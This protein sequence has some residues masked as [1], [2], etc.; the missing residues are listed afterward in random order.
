[1]AAVW[2]RPDNVGPEFYDSDAYRDLYRLARERLVEIKIDR[3][4]ITRGWTYNANIYLVQPTGTFHADAPHIE[5]CRFVPHG[6][7]SGINP[8][9]AHI[10]AMR[11]RRLHHEPLVAVAI[12]QA[13]LWLLA[14]AYRLARE[15]EERSARIFGKLDAAMT[16]LTDLIRSYTVPPAAP[17]PIPA[18]PD[19]DDDL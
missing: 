17:Q 11:I 9:S 3:S 14:R 13:E 7:G 18:K 4:N 19:E 6:A 5:R 12:L 1:M 16:D 10:D 2:Y 8:L 15:R